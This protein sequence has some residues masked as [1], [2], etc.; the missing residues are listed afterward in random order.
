VCGRAAQLQAAKLKLKLPKIWKLLSR[1]KLKV[2][3]L[4]NLITSMTHQHNFW[5]VAVCKFYITYPLCLCTFIPS[6]WVV[7]FGATQ[8]WGQP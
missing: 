4:Q 7:S 3:C 1:S 6:G 2:K 8:R 5:S